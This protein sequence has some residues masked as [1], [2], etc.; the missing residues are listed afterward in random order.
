[1]DSL[2]KHIPRDDARWIGQILSR[3]SSAQI[4]DAFRAGGYTPD[5][6]EA[7]TKVIQTR[8]AE[9]NSL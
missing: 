5:Q 8:I 6:I 1:M 4:H 2:G 9:L 7:F 3:L